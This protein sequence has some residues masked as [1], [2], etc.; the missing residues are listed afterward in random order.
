MLRTSSVHDTGTLGAAARE[1]ARVRDHLVGPERSARW[2]LPRLEPLT[3]LC[4]A[5]LLDELSR[6]RQRGRF[7]RNVARGTKPVPQFI[8]ERGRRCAVAHL[9]EISG[10]GGLV[11]HI[12]H[13]DNDARVHALAPLPELRAWLAALLFLVGAACGGQGSSAT[14][15]D[16]AE[17]PRGCGLEGQGVE[18]D[19][20]SAAQN[21]HDVGFVKSPAEGTGVVA[22]E[23]TGYPPDLYSTRVEQC[24]GRGLGKVAIGAPIP[25]SSDG[26]CPADASCGENKVCYLAAA[27]DTD[28]DCGGGSA[29]VCAG[30]VGDSAAVGYNQCIP[31]E[32]R[33]D[34]DCG[35]HSCA[36]SNAAPC[37]ELAGR[38]CHTEA[39]ECARHSDCGDRL[40]AFDSAVRAWRCTDSSRICDE[41]L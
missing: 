41:G 9:M 12:A 19:P 11:W 28:V 39:D 8:D 10:Q 21:C 18:D 14:R 5:L 2:R 29:C 15:A 31:T 36:I 13:T 26:E 27:C 3:A 24:S 4:R 7:P 17:Q 23:S 35:G 32:C 34:A 30:L 25:C 22:C 37:G 40:C 6:Y 38:H 16:C 33:S 20:R 1:Q